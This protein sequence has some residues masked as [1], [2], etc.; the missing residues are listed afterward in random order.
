MSDVPVRPPRAGVLLRP[1]FHALFGV[2]WRSVRLLVRA[3]V[4]QSF[5][6]QS[7]ELYRAYIARLGSLQCWSS[8]KCWPCDI[9]LFTVPGAIRLSVQQVLSPLTVLLEG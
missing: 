4:L 7:L 3:I 2:Q 5:S 1:I 6:L 8:A 9:D